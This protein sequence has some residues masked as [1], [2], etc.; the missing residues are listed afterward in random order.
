MDV[1]IKD[2]EISRATVAIASLT[3]DIIEIGERFQD[4]MEGVTCYGFISRT[5]SPLLL[6]RARFVSEQIAQLAK[7][8]ENIG[9]LTSRM[10]QDI[11]EK[12]KFLY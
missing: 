6:E 12:D 3:D 11:D 10:V 9:I 8:T 7:Q 4:V 1:I 2:D 5:V